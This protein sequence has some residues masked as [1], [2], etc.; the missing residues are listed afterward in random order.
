MNPTQNDIALRLSILKSAYESFK[1]KQTEQNKTE[2]VAALIQVISLVNTGFDHKTKEGI[3]ARHEFR[4]A[5]HQTSNDDLLLRI[6]EMIHK[7]EGLKLY[8]T[9]L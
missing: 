6:S 7:T 4:D 8:G 5:C 1:K 9:R 3:Q 2:A